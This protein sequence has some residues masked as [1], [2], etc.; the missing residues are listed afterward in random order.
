MVNCN[1]ETVSTD[2]DTSDRLYFEPLTLED[3]LEVVHAEQQAGPVVGVIVQLGGQTPLGLAQ[4]LQG[5]GRADRRAPARRRSTWPRSAARSAGCWRRPGCR[6]PKH[7]IAISFAE[8]QGDRRRDRL[9]GAGAPVATCSAGAAW[10]SSTTSRSLADYIERP[11]GPDLRAPG[12]GRPVPRR[13]DRDRRRRAVRR[14]GAVPRRRD[15]AHRGG[16]HPLRRLGLRAAADHPRRLRHRADP[17][18][19]RGDRPGRRG[20]GPAQRP[21]RA[22]RGRPLRARGQ[23]AGLAHRAVRL[24][25][26]GGA[27]GQGGRPDHARRHG[28]R[29][30]GRGPAAGLGRRRHAAAGL[31]DRG[32]GGRAAVR[33]SGP[34]TARA[35]TSC[36]AR[37]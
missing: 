12:A 14:R 37:R 19:D 29:A 30:A 22:R 32:Q 24:Q 2:Y 3:V 23:P 5:R 6:A 16:R 34:R 18:L 26:H 28:R 10:R 25:G 11:R 36:S 8:A 31:A 21:V 17:H 15:G 27:A 13:R 1:P 35:W 33:A 7:G 20:A 4:R 9:P